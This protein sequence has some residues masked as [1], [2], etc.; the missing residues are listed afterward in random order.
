MD[1]RTCIHDRL[2]SVQCQECDEMD[3][4]VS[5]RSRDDELTHL[6]AIVKAQERLVEAVGQVLP[7][8]TF[9]SEGQ[10]KALY[11]AYAALREEE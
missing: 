7:I 2:E 6:R 1:E 8:L 9:R 5:A 3:H 11:D 10:V 4:N